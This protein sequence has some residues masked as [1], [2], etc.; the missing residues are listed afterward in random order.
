MKIRKYYVIFFYILQGK[1]GKMEENGKKIT[2]LK[3]PKYQKLKDKNM[4]WIEHQWPQSD[5]TYRSVREA[6]GGM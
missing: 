1:M 4:G 3:W 5:M 6:A 2:Q